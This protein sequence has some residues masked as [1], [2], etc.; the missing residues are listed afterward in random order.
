MKKQTIMFSRFVYGGGV[1]PQFATKIGFS[2]TENMHFDEKV[3]Y[4][5]DLFYVSDYSGSFDKHIENY[6]NN[7]FF[8]KSAKNSEL[9]ELVR[10]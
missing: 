10:N 3:D 8:R 2:E 9:Y 4:S 7:Y 1:N 6:K 5:F